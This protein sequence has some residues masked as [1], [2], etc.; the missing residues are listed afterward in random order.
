M[1]RE[2]GLSGR[3]R[4]DRKPMI[5]PLVNG[6]ESL[7]LATCWFQ[8]I[9]IFGFKSSIRITIAVIPYIKVTAQSVRKFKVTLKETNQTNKIKLRSN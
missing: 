8:S 5:R 3:W 7:I 1:L 9:F 6:T 4:N 2:T